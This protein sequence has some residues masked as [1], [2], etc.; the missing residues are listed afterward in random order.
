MVA[1]SIV[2]LAMRI[3]MDWQVL[4]WG[5]LGGVV[6]DWIPTEWVSV[7][8]ASLW[9]GFAFSLALSFKVQHAHPSTLECAFSLLN[10]QT[11]VPPPPTPSLQMSGSRGQRTQGSVTRAVDHRL[12]TKV[13]VIVSIAVAG[14]LGGAMAA[15]IGA[16]ADTLLFAVMVLR[17][18]VDAV[19]A[20]PT[21][22][23]VSKLTPSAVQHSPRPCRIHSRARL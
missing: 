11:C 23:V 16:G 14:V 12:T 1:A 4:K 18:R 3:D 19:I 6:P 21:S 13:G 9:C 20:Q 22:V 8:F 2:G 10:T 5:G 15:L 7:G 17:Y